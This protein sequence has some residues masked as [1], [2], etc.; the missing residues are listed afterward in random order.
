MLL[1]QQEP[2]TV[3]LEVCS[4][5]W[6]RPVKAK[7][8]LAMVMWLVTAVALLALGSAP[9]TADPDGDYLALL[10]AVKADPA[11]ADYRSQSSSS[12]QAMPGA[13]AGRSYAK[14]WSSQRN[15]KR[16]LPGLQVLEEY[17]ELGW[18]KSARRIDG[19]YE[20]LRRRPIRKKPDQFTARELSIAI[21]R[22][23]ETNSVASIGKSAYSLKISRCDGARNA[24]LDGFLAADQMPFRLVVPPA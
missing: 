6:R 12:C 20:D 16:T 18:Q 15:P 9:A 8:V 1:S 3:P 2:A 21:G 17:L 7:P 5:R 24:Q 4:G 13:E 22:G 19:M 23:Q 14:P 11:N 10:A